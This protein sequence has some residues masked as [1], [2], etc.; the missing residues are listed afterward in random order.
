MA[1]ALIGLAGALLGAVTALVGAAP[2]D[3]RQLNNEE[4]RWRR[5]QMGTAYE[6][7]LRYLLRAANRR[8][9]VD[10]ELGRGVLSKEPQR[11]WYD[12]LVD[13]HSWLLILISRCGT[14]Q[15]P[16]LRDTF[17]LLDRQI[18]AL[19]ALTGH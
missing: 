18:Q 4:V 11:E 16:P 17:D 9:Q 8:S 19:G 10:P 15:A 12:D 2:S 1:T 7:T 14:G 3:R 5:D 6:T 13:G